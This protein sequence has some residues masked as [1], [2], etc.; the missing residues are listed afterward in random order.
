MVRDGSQSKSKPSMFSFYLIVA[1]CV[2]VSCQQRRPR[3]VTWPSNPFIGKSNGNASLD[4][5]FVL[6]PNETWNGSIFEVVFGVWRY[7]GYLKKKLMVID[8]RGEVLIRRNYEKKISC[9][10]NMSRLQVAF[11]LHNLSVED[12]KRYGLQV[13]FGL[14]RSPLT[15]TVTLRIEDPPKITNPLQRNVTVRTG[16]D[17]DLNCQASGVPDPIV[18][19]IRLGRVIKNQTLYFKRVTASDSGLYL[20]KANNQAGEDSKEIIVTVSDNNDKFP[21][22][23]DFP[24][25]P[26][27]SKAAISPVAWITLAVICGSLILIALT[28]LL[29]RF[30]RRY[31]R[32]IPYEPQI[33]AKTPSTH[34]IP[35]AI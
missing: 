7:P 22:I 15:D 14:A 12:E 26:A 29:S 6:L 21:Q 5:S 18:T 4:W 1:L 27:P 13:E 8:T 33:N 19:W 16:E 20:C 30:R 23:T 28:V 24:S 3:I 11:T 34:S 25:T 32:N 2:S 17:L 35:A 9:K 10:F 31:K